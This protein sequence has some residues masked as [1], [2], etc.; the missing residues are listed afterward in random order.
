MVQKI[1]KNDTQQIER[2]FPNDLKHIALPENKSS[3][4]NIGHPKRKVFV[5]QSWI[6]RA[7]A[8]GFGGRVLHTEN[9]KLGLCKSPL[10]GGFNPFEKY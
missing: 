2:W 10:A 8:V 6:F 9:G 4:L 3:P 5:C 7:V 1:Q